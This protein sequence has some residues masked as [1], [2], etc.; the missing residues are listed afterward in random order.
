MAKQEI[1]DL[2][3][4]V[5]YCKDIINKSNEPFED[6]KAC[7]RLDGYDCRTDKEVLEFLVGRLQRIKPTYF[8]ATTLLQELDVTNIVKYK[9]P[10]KDRLLVYC[11]TIIRFLDR[12]EWNFKDI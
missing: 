7:I 9:L 3:T 12:N 5:K 11:M 1:F 10:I 6:L 4:V 2:T 8:V